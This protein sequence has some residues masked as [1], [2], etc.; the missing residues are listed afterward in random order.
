MHISYPHHLRRN[1]KLL[2]LSMLCL[3]SSFAIGIKSAGEVQP[4]TIIEAGGMTQAGDV[5]ENGT[6][7]LQDVILI[8]EFT[9]GYSVPS[10]EQLKADPTGDGQ[11]TVDDALRILSTLSLR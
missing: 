1:A 10:P 3:V 9:K 5:D 11:F 6:V 4:F 8:L 7:D 2:A